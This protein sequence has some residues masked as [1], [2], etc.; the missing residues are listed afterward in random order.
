VTEYA[1]I[2]WNTVIAHTFSDSFPLQVSIILFVDFL[3][4][5]ILP[6]VR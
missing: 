5:A 3:M 1:L 4:I 6:G 2:G